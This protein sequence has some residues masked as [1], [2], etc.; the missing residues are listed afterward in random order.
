MGVPIYMISTQAARLDPVSTAVFER[1]SA[2]TGG[3]AYFAKDWKDQQRAFASVR[4]DLSHLC[5]LT[6]YPQPNANLGWRR[7]TVKLVGDPLKTYHIRTRS[8]YRPKV[9]RVPGEIAQTP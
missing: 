7:I 2:S 8:G 1:I 3:K 4:D 9:I 5:A 6:Y